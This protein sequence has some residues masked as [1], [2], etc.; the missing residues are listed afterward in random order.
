MKD[1]EVVRELMLQIIKT[2][3]AFRQALQRIL[4]RNNIDMTFEMLQI[5]NCLW[6]EQGISQQT[7]AEKTAKDKAC[8]TSLMGNLEKKGWIVRKESTIDRRNRQV[9]LTPEGEA[10]SEVILP[11]IRELYQQAGV[12]MGTEEINT[13]IN[14]LKR[15]D[16]ILN[17]LG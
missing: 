1:Y 13:S 14:Q 2:R 7:L 3:T 16:E 11:L 10:M 8:L 5:M 4:K 12:Q 15:L 17:Q 9:F 6:H